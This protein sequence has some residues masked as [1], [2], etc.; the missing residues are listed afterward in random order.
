[1]MN[2]I[3]HCYMTHEKTAAIRC[4][5]YIIPRAKI[6]VKLYFNRHDFSAHE[7]HTR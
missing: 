6:I 2:R 7:Q 4:L 5:G 1:M 3:N